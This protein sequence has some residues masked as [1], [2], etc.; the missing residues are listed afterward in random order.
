LSFA[1]KLVNL[2]ARSGHTRGPIES[3]NTFKLNCQLVC[4]FTCRDRTRGYESSQ[5]Q[6]WVTAFAWEKKRKRKTARKMMVPTHASCKE[7]NESLMV[8]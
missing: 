8:S 3:L 7:S 4:I 6:H 2:Y 1:A 5:V